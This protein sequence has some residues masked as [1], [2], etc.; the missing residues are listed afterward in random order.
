[1]SRNGGA[2]VSSTSETTSVT[3]SNRGASGTGRPQVTAGLGGR[4]VP[5]FC[6]M[7]LARGLHAVFVPRSETGKRP[8]RHCGG[9][10]CLGASQDAHNQ[11]RAH[12]RVRRI[13]QARHA[14]E[15]LGQPRV[16][17][18]SSVQACHVRVTE[19]DLEGPLPSRHPPGKPRSAPAE[20]SHGTLM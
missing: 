8:D 3:E 4:A 18:S 19:A 12:Q 1:M 2:S 15:C 17:R 10:L 16:M 20:I 13:N 6:S 9:L 11:A 14:E 7:K 5:G